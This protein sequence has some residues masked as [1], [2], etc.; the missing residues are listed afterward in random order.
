MAEPA[1]SLVPVPGAPRNVTL[2]FCPASDPPAGRLVVFVHGFAGSAVKTWRA[3]YEGQAR[4][5]WWRES[6]L[7]F[8]GYRSLHDEVGYVAST[9]RVLVGRAFPSPQDGMLPLRQGDIPYARLVLVGHSL[10]GVILRMALLEELRAQPSS[11]LLAAA[12][13]LFS[14]ATGGF[15]PSGLLGA[16]RELGLWSAVEAVLSG[17]PSYNLLRRKIDDLARLRGDTEQA[18]LTHPWLPSLSSWT[19]W[20]TPDRVVATGGYVTDAPPEWENLGHTRVCKPG[21][22]YTRPWEFIQEKV[23]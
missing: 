6:D 9:L 11:P 2:F 17:A 19:L 7:L 22:T 1:F 5:G 3:F 16:F 18:A 4:Y 8:V 12:L 10:G 21:P 14:P 23:R 20:A 13:L 15:V